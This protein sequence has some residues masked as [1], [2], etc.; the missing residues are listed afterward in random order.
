[1]AR[2][3]REA[4]VGLVSV[5]RDRSRQCKVQNPPRVMPLLALCC[6]I[7]ICGCDA[8][9]MIRMDV[10]SG[11]REMVRVVDLGQLDQLPGVPIEGTVV[12]FWLSLGSLT[13]HRGPVVSGQDGTL[14]A[15]YTIGGFPWDVKSMNQLEV[16][17]SCAKP[18]Y[19]PVEGTFRLDGFL[20]RADRHGQTV[21]VVM[22][23]AEGQ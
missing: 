17:F 16:D 13:E 14:R 10:R 18:G 5:H 8:L 4:Q 7:C 3:Q 20:G 22:P 15:G 12:D 1:M 11:K 19:V 2:L 23:P 6:V 9:Y 21:L